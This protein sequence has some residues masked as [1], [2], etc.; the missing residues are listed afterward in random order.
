[1][2]YFLDTCI[3]VHAKNLH[4]PLS[5]KSGFWGWLLKLGMDGTVRIPEYVFKEV[6]RGKDDLVDWMNIHKDIFLCKTVE[7]IHFMPQTLVAYGNPTLNEAELE[8]L[9][10]DPY[11][12]AHALAV[13]GT[14][15]SDEIPN[16]A[17][18]PKNKKVPVVCKALSVPC[19]TLPAFMWELRQTMLDRG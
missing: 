5:E 3:L 14:V 10:A 7:C 6:N 17:T 1:V 4:F 12:I 11:L 9:E 16:R 19:L 15:V 13:G 18:A 2:I 8:I